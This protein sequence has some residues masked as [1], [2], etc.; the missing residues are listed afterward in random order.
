MNRVS[1]V[2]KRRGNQRF[3]VEI[4]ARTTPGQSVG[5]VGY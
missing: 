5:H 1:A 3:D 2:R 4:G